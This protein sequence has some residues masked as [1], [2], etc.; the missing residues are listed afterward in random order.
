MKGSIVAGGIVAFTAIFGAGLY[1]SQTYAYYEP[2]NTSAVEAQVSATTLSGTRED[3]LAE[4]FEGI[5]AD[6]SPIKYRACF[7]TP[8]SQAM[9]TETFVIH[10]APTPLTAPS[11]F[12]CFDAQTLTADLEAGAAIAFMGT[13]NITYG[14]DRV[15]AVYP[16]GRAYAWHQ[17]NDCGATVYDGEVAPEGC[18]PAPTFV[19]E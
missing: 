10:D 16:D 7:S 5:D 18:P 1:Y 4:N 2:I 13:E 3:L 14:V 8:L 12:D 9:L 15:V 11:W 17:I 19:G 6:T